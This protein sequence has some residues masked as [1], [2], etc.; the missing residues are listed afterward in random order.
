M[1]KFLKSDWL[2][3]MQFSVI[4][5]KMRKYNGNPGN[6]KQICHRME[7]WL[8]NKQ[9]NYIEPIRSH[10]LSWPLWDEGWDWVIV[11]SNCTIRLFW[12]KIFLKKNFSCLLLKSIQSDMTFLQFGV[13]LY[14]LFFFKK[15][16]WHSLCRV[17]NFD[18]F[19]KNHS[20]E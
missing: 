3:A 7:L 4:T 15:L 9:Y 19:W 6:K 16:K 8:A 20:W 1:K 14:T 10:N 13:Y 17:W 11:S 5:T 2:R 18:T 12:W